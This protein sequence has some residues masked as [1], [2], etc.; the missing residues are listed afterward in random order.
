M[1]KF[2]FKGQPTAAE[3]EALKVV[4]MGGTQLTIVP[5]SFESRDKTVHTIQLQGSGKP[6]TMGAKKALA[7]IEAAKEIEE[8]FRSV[9]EIE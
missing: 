5:N 7:I 1:S 6:L 9:G 2:Q 3:T 8:Y 4:D